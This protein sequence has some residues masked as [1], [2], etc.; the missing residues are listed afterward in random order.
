MY[1]LYNVAKDWKLPPPLAFFALLSPGA[2]P[3]RKIEMTPKLQVSLDKQK[4]AHVPDEWRIM[5]EQDADL[6]KRL[7]AAIV[8]S[9]SADPAALAEFTQY[10]LP[11]ILYMLSTYSGRALRPA[12]GAAPRPPRRLADLYDARGN[13]PETVTV[14]KAC[15]YTHRKPRWI[16]KL[17]A[18][19]RL[20]TR[21][22]LKGNRRIITESLLAFYPPEE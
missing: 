8:A 18:D 4:H 3:L 7:L 22:V 5:V 20:K 11:E 15:K 14:T 19:D 17:I 16:K 12:H 2:K 13:L 1:N 21:G 6:R 9:L 10:S